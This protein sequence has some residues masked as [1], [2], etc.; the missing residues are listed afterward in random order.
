MPCSS[1]STFVCIKLLNILLTFAQLVNLGSSASSLAIIPFSNWTFL[2]EHWTLKSI[3]LISLRLGPKI[4]S[5]ESSPSQPSSCHRFC[6]PTWL[7]PWWVSLQKF[8]RLVRRLP[9]KFL[10][11]NHLSMLN[12]FRSDRLLLDF[13][14]PCTNRKSKELEIFNPLKWRFSVS[15]WFSLQKVCKLCFCQPFVYWCLDYFEFRPGR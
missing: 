15:F 9:Y 14:V 6:Q 12:E 7:H 10:V 1:K 3:S 13:K 4:W 8:G 2:S 11:Q 5:F